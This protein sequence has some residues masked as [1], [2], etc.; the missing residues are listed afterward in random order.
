MKNVI[1][2]I[3]IM[4]ILSIIFNV[5]RLNHSEIII[6]KVTGTERI[7]ETSGSGKD[8]SVT[9][10][11]LVFTENETFENIDETFAGKWN[12]SDFQGRFAKDSTYKVKVVGW[13]IP[14]TSTYRNIVQIIP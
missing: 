13:R 7:T 3:V 11:Y 1:I 4:L 10:K 14:M 6:I 12:S 2:I 9:S 5:V 8:L